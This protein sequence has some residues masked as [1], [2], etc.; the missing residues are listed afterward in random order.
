LAAFG[1]VGTFLVSSDLKPWKNP[2]LLD[3]R[4]TDDRH[5]MAI[6]LAK[7]KSIDAQTINGVLKD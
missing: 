7:N 2:K 4:I 3:I 1:M 5:I 6:D